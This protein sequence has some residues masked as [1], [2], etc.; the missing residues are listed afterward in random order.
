[1]KIE[2]LRMYDVSPL[3]IYTGDSLFNLGPYG[4]FVRPFLIRVDL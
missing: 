1:M 4:N 3:Y 2:M